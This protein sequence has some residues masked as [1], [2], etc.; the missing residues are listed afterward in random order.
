MMQRL[1]LIFVHMPKAGGSSLCAAIEEYFSPDLVLRDY[2]DRPN[3]PTSPMN[4]D[5]HGFLERA[6]GRNETA[7][8]GKAAVFGHFWIKKYD[9]VA[10]DRRTIILREP[11]SRAISHYFF[12]KSVAFDHPLRQYV[13]ANDLSFLQF[14]RLPRVNSLYTQIYFRDVD[15][16]RFDFI[17]NYDR[18]L[19]DWTGTVIALGLE[20]PPPPRELNAT[21]THDSDYMAKRSQILCDA[22]LMAQLRDIFA[23]DLRFYER[24]GLR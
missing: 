7:L 10:A 1:E 23:D 21:T 14:A 16:G 22:S 24:Y 11:I 4:L 13:I 12:W 18:L 3:D 19:P 8:S 20:P 6:R 17:G 15:M 9:D 2:E 5:P